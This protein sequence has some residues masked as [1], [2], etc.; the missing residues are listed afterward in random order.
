[1]FLISFV[2]ACRENAVGTVNEKLMHKLSLQAPPR[3]LVE[4]YLIEIAKSHN[5]PYE[6]D[7]TV[8]NQEEV[9]VAEAM[10]IDFNDNRNRPGG[11]GGGV[12]Y[13]PAPGFV[14][15]PPSQG[16]V[17]P[18]QVH[19]AAVPFSYPTKTEPLPPAVPPAMP[20]MPPAA[21]YPGVSSKG[22]MND[23]LDSLGPA[24]PYESIAKRP[25]SPVQP[26]KPSPA[27]RKSP[28]DTLPEL[29]SVPSGSLTFNDDAGGTNTN[30]EDVD[31]D[32]LSKRFEELKKRK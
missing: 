10:L 7:P 28:S 11:P 5:V 31:F 30:A 27:P 17:P 20:S 1:L 24:P 4:R 8:M 14:V 12:A 21:G 18:P 3:I 19:P 16:F 29:P 32:D 6:P 2:Q 9:M 15:P 26:Y 22:S 23:Y 25:P 13:P